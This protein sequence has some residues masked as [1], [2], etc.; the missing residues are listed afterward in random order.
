M[1]SMI[2]LEVSL[3]IV[4]N[5]TKNMFEKMPNLNDLTVELSRM[6]LDGNEWEQI[7]INYLP[8]IKVFRLKMIFAFFSDT[9]KEEQIDQI[10]DTFRSPFWLEKHQWFVRCRWNPWDDTKLVTL[11]TLPYAFNTFHYSDGCCSRSTCLNKEDYQFYN[12]VRFIYQYKISS[13][14][15]L[16]DLN[17]FDTYFPNIRHLSVA[18]PIDN[19]FLRSCQSLDTLT[20][21]EVFLSTDTGYDQFQALLDQTHNLYSL[22]LIS[23]KKLHPALFHLTSKSI[24]RLDLTKS[25]LDGSDYFNDEDCNKLIRSPLGLQCEVLLIHV[26]NRINVLDLIEKMSNL[27]LLI[28]GCNDD[29]KFLRN[30]SSTNDELVQWLQNHFSSTYLIIRDQG[31]PS[32]IQVWINR[33]KEIP[34]SNI[35]ISKDQH[36]IFRSLKSNFP[37]FFRKS[38]V[39]KQNTLK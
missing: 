26:N 14:N 4:Q 27:R 23:N 15:S 28:F 20:S 33:Q 18:I 37:V 5:S 6:Y 10:L 7:I 1:P 3:A 30:S 38:S 36:K 21:L 11:Y 9:K 31:Y 19:N 13:R 35:L 24:H 2:A 12:H 8:K 16:E 32:Y 17:L 22:K 25:S 39:Y 29:K 34:N